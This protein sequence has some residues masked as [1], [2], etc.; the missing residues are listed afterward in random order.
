MNKLFGTV[1]SFK[2]A[3]GIAFVKVDVK[4]F[5]VSVMSLGGGWKIGEG[6]GVY[7]KESDVMV[8][9]RES[10]RLSARNKFLSSVVSVS[11]NGVLA[12]IE[13]EFAQER[14]CSLISSEAY[15]ELE[16]KV[17]QEFLWFVKSNEILLERME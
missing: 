15:R 12:R 14:I 16:I 13:F 4:G 2:E 8:A 11:E 17:G 6:V 9:H 5:I 10:H 7:F 3:Q 1:I